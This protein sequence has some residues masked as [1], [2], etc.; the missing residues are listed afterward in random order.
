MRTDLRKAAKQA[1][2]KSKDK[3]ERAVKILE[4][5]SPLRGVLLRLGAQQVIRNYFAMQRDSAMSMATGRVLDTS[6]SPAAQKRLAARLARVAFWD[7]YTL[8]GMTPI[9]SA[10]KK[11]LIDSASQREAQ[12]NTELRL[13]KFERAV[14]GRLLT[15]RATV[16][17]SMTIMELEKLAAKHKAGT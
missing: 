12:G 2:E 16:S 4:C 5:V 9:R 8:F 1:L 7:A 10:T 13:A 15:P 11:Q 3:P 6:D 17:S 14:A